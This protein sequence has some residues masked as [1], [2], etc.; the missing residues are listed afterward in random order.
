MLQALLLPVRFQKDLSVLDGDDMGVHLYSNGAWKDS[1]KI[2]RNSANILITANVDSTVNGITCR[3]NI[4]GSYT[5][6]GN[7][8][9]SVANFGIS[10]SGEYPSAQVISEGTYTVSAVGGTVNCFFI[11]GGSGS[12]AGITYREFKNDDPYTFTCISG[13]IG[14]CLVRV[15]ASLNTPVT[16]YPMLNTGP[17]ALPYEPYNV[18]DWYTNNGHSYSSGAWS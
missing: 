16:I 8:E 1:G 2:Y 11:F 10:G 7:L 4:D 18:V 9:G 3:R 5:F 6:S 13:T 12:T 17:T 15:V 14:Y